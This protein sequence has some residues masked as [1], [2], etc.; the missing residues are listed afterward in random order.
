MELRLIFSGTAL[1]PT[2]GSLNLSTVA[3]ATAC[4]LPPQY[5]IIWGTPAMDSTFSKMEFWK[6][7]KGASSC[8]KGRDPGSLQ[9][10]SLGQ[11]P[12]RP[13]SPTPVMFHALCPH[14]WST[15]LIPYWTPRPTLKVTASTRAGWT[16]PSPD[17][18]Q[19]SKVSRDGCLERG[20]NW[21]LLIG[22]QSRDF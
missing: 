20:L 3:M 7:P 10:L 15:G 17:T 9:G 1:Q 6:F 18:Q 8:S 4:F 16:A 11:C 19:C 22:A 14:C 12:I 2:E 13:S 21:G 5:E